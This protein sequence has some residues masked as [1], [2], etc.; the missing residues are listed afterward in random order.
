MKPT[1]KDRGVAGL[2]IL[3]SVVTMIFVIG[4]LVMIFALMGG[5]LRDE[6]QTRSANTS[7]VNESATVVAATDLAV[8]GY[9]DVDCGNIAVVENTTEAGIVTSGN[10]SVTTSASGCVIANLTTLYSGDWNVTYS[11]TYDVDSTAS[12]TI[13]NTTSSISGVTSWFPIII[14][15]TAMVVLILLTVIIITAIRSSGLMGGGEGGSQMSR[16]QEG[17]KGGNI[18]TA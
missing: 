1:K 6:T 2:T 3:L 12:S 10:Y 14:V 13:E 17:R 7:I 18:G 9:D 4:L 15:I 5:E 16:G 8:A 11:Y